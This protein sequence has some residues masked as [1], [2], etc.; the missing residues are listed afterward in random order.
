MDDFS[1]VSGRLDWADGDSSPREIKVPILD[2]THHEVAE[3][4]TVAIGSPSG[5]AV[6]LNT[7]AQ[8]TID[9]DDEASAP[10]PPPPPPPPP[11]GGGGATDGLTLAFLLMAVAFGLVGRDQEARC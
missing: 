2:D 6:L 4:F 3:L 10:P 5:G 1:A 11:S 7:Q 8:V 9:D